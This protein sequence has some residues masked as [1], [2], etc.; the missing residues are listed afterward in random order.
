MAVVG[1]RPAGR[2]RRTPGGRRSRSAGPSGRRRPGCQP[3]AVRPRGAARPIS[4]RR[5]SPRRA[6]PA[7]PAI[8]P[9][10]GSRPCIAALTRLLET[11]A[12]ATARAST[13]SLA[14]ETPQVIRVVAPS[15]SAACWRARSRPTASTAAPRAAASA[16]PGRIG[17]AADAPEARRKTVSFVLVSPSTESWFQVRT[18]ADAEQ[19]V[20]G[21]RTDRGVRQDDRQHG[22]HP[23][24]DHADALGHAGDGHRDR[25]FRPGP[26]APAGLRPS[27]PP[28]RSSAGPRP[29]PRTRRRRSR[30]RCRPEWLPQRPPSPPEAGF[31]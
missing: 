18:V 11:T 8:L 27:W 4:R 3:A 26:G 15:P 13:S 28:S 16:V 21:G 31:R 9:Q 24:V 20:E 22:R 6:L 23:R 5:A 7:A 1:G 17:P 29:P 19:A 14:P 30:G 2:D 25:A 10:F 12:R